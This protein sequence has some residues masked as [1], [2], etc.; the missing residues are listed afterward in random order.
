MNKLYDLIKNDINVLEDIDKE[1]FGFSDA[2]NYSLSESRIKK[3]YQLI[4]DYSKKRNLIVEKPKFP[5]DNLESLQEENEKNKISNALNNIEN[6]FSE[7]DVNEMINEVNKINKADVVV[8]GNVKFKTREELVKTYNGL[9]KTLENSIMLSRELKNNVVTEIELLDTVKNEISRIIQNGMSNSVLSFNNDELYDEMQEYIKDATAA[10]SKHHGQIF[11]NEEEKEE[12]ENVVGVGVLN[13]NKRQIV[14]QYLEELDDGDFEESKELATKIITLVTKYI[15]NRND[16]L[17]DNVNNDYAPVGRFLYD[18]KEKVIEVI[19]DNNTYLG[20]DKHSNFI[21][22]FLHNPVNSFTEIIDRNV[23]NLAERDLLQDRLFENE[24]TNVDFD[25]LIRRENQLK[26]YFLNERENYNTAAQN[27]PDVWQDRQRIYSKN[28]DKYFKQI[29]NNV[30]IDQTLKNNKGGFFE[31]LFGTTSKEYKE[32]SD[33]LDKFMKEGPLNGDLDGLR[34]K[35]TAY[36]YH[37]L[38][39]YDDNL[40]KIDEAE[41]QKLD[42]T[43]RGRVKLCLSVVDAIDKANK[44]S[45]K[46]IHGSIDL[47]DEMDLLKQFSKNVEMEKFQNDLKNDSNSEIENN[48]NNIIDDNSNNNIDK[49]D[50]EL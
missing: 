27:K 17:E 3:L 14:N 30:T 37:K 31:N 40:N 46:E 32:F 21:K 39:N 13:D 50:V 16:F 43:S 15:K 8:E 18:L 11:E 25:A 28:F 1:D 29:M 20:N 5:F 12:F 45:R 26:E 33:G 6:I 23:K 38:G 34:D 44:D 19:D 24:D 10:F 35:A 4:D 42:S 9:Q 49:D 2:V 22:S 48:N 41:L 7:D 36:L 47:G